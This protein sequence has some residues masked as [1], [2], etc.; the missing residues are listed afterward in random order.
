MSINKYI[1]VNVLIVKLIYFTANDTRILF[2]L[3]EYYETAQ[4]KEKKLVLI[5]KFYSIK[6]IE[7]NKIHQYILEV[8]LSKSC[9]IVTWNQVNRELY[10]YAYIIWFQC[11]LMFSSKKSGVSQ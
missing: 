9:K 4:K 5:T 2:F 10:K 8:K 1:P 6:T 3:M 11:V 7:K